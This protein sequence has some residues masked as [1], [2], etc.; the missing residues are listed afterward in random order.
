MS[1][2]VDWVKNPPKELRV[3][4]D[5]KTGQIRWAQDDTKM[6]GLKMKQSL[7]ETFASGSEK[8]EIMLSG[9]GPF[10]TFLNYDRKKDSSSY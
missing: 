5:L 2:K 1:E 3:V 9:N 10:V 6:R 7:L 4:I 8:I